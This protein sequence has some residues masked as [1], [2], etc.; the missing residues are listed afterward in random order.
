MRGLKRRLDEAKGK[1]TEEL[2]S[3]LWSYR[4]TPHSTTEETPFRLTYG[5]EAVI[6]VEI[7]ASSFRTEILIEDE[8]NDEMLR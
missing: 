6:P 4:T 3:V 7:E 1:W 2:D 8:L 5:T